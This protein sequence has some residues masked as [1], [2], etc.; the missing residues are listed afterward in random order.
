MRLGVIGQA[1]DTHCLRLMKAIEARG[2]TP[3][4]IDSGDP[5][6][7]FSIASDGVRYD[8]ARVDDI[9]VFFLRAV[10][11]PVPH[12]FVA[13][14]VMRLYDDWH[15]QYMRARE[16]HGF[17]LSWLLALMARGARILNAPQW[18]HIGQLKP[19]HTD[20]LIRAGLPVPTSIITSDPAEARAFLQRHPEAVYKPVMGGDLARRVDANTL[21]RLDVIRQSPVILQ[22]LVA[23]DA[24]RVTMTAERILSVCHIVSDTL[25]FRESTGYLEGRA[26]YESATL[27]PEIE[28]LCFR[29]IAVS[30]YDYTAIDLIRA[31]PND[32][33]FLECNYAPAFAQ[34]EDRTGH[35]ITEGILDYMLDAAERGQP[36]L[37][38]HPSQTLFDYR[39]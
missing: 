33:F 21:R 8:G 36:D 28:A 37:R 20:A 16:K 26:R 35:P 2:H 30:G 12:V 5:A 14:G 23:G 7:T 24:I 1:K 39:R 32:Y 3:V 22:A 9:P 19:F 18:A 4:L 25:D 34:I 38:P 13:D 11:S 31:F 15:A 27:P 10:M 29:A 17:L 6:R